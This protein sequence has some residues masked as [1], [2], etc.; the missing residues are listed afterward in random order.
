ME[1]LFIIALFVVSLPALV[2]GLVI[3]PI[4]GYTRVRRRGYR[5]PAAVLVLLCGTSLGLILVFLIFPRFVLSER[6]DLIFA[7]TFWVAT[8]IS[9]AATAL[10]IRLL[11]RCNARVAGRR[12]PRFPLVATGLG[13]IGLGVV[14][15]VWAIWEGRNW[16]DALKLLGIITGFGLALMALGKGVKSAASIEEVATFTGQ[17]L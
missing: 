11:P 4:A 13:L 2:I 14:F 17:G 5:P 8:L 9:V 10:I 12:K 16:G 15:V 7:V 6:V 3:A 1:L